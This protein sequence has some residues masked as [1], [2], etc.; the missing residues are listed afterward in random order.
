M[1]VCDVLV[2][3]AVAVTVAPMRLRGMVRWYGFVSR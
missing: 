2:V 3:L 1:V